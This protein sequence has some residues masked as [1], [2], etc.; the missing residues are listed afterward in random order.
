MGIV[1]LTPDSFSGDGLLNEADPVTAAL[2]QARQ[3]VQAGV[4]ILDLGAES[5]RPGA[6]TVTAD[7]EQQRLLPVLHALVQAD[8]DV[9]ISIDT[10]RASRRR[11]RW[12]RGALD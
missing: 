6:Q 2:Q 1:N 11:R 4:D 7:E 9:L 3:F 12:R 8:L 5:T 10:Y